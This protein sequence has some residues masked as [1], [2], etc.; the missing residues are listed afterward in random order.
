MLGGKLR[1]REAREVLLPLRP[2]LLAIYPPVM[3]QLPAQA[4]HDAVGERQV[5]LSGMHAEA[6]EVAHEGRGQHCPRPACASAASFL[7]AGPA[8]DYGEAVSGGPDLGHVPPKP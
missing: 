5:D 4:D 6:C 8:E 1:A 7:A 2:P 3:T